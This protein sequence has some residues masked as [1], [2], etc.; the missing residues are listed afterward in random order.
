MKISG[1]DQ[2]SRSLQEAQKAIAAID[3]ELGSVH[4]DPNDPTSIEVA[5][6]QANAM[7]DDRIGKYASN[8]FVAPLVNEM[9]EQFRNAIVERSAAARLGRKDGE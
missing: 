8:P 5:I 7:I 3:G 2:L 6:A 4:F 9:K 1:L